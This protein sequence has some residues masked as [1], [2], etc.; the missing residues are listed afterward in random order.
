M[1]NKNMTIYD[2]INNIISNVDKTV[3][4]FAQPILNTN[5][6]SPKLSIM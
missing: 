2:P 5:L 1:K 4:L 6:F 3:N